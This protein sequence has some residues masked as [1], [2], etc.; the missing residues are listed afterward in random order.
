MKIIKGFKLREVA[1]QSVVA[2]EGLGQIDFNKLITLN[3]TAA[4][5]WK[6]VENSD[7][8]VETLADLLVDNYDVD[9]TTATKDATDI[10]DEWLKAKIVEA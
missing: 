3:P 9:K 7:F 1:G 2:G 4:F 5:L 10:A 6:Q 8:T